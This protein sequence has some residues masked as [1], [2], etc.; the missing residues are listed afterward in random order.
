MP[1]WLWLAV[2]FVVIVIIGFVCARKRAKQPISNHQ[3]LEMSYVSTTRALDDVGVPYVHMYGTALGIH[4]NAELIPYDDDVDFAIYYE[5]LEACQDRLLSSMRA[6]GLKIK[7]GGVPFQ[8][9]CGTESLPVLFQFEHPVTKMNCDIYIMY[10]YKGDVWVFCDGGE[11]DGKGYCYPD[12]APERKMYRGRQVLLMP[13]QWLELQYGH[14]WR[15]PQ[16]G[17][18]GAMERELFLDTIPT[19]VLPGRDVFLGN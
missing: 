4:R 12:L 17:S 8:W 13:S 9:A 18:K 2:G 10:R 16:P 11:Q 5:D 6:R 7:N 15:I 14:D 19:C 3:A 1:C